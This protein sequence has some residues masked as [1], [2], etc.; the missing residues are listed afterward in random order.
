[1]VNAPLISIIIPTYNVAEYLFQCLNSIA[2]QT[3][4]NFEVIIIIDGATDN[5][6]DIA[7]RF[8]KNDNRFSVYWQENAG[9]GPARNNGLCRATGDFIMF[10]DPDD[11]CK[12]DYIETMLHL[13]QRNDYDLVTVS[14]T[15]VYFNK[16]GT[17]KKTQPP[18][19]HEMQF[20]GAQ[21]VHNNYL[22]LLKEGAIQAPH[23]R[24]YKASIIKKHN[25]R[26]P[27]LRRSQDIVFNYRYY[28]YVQSVLVCN[29]SG[30]MYRVLSK[31]R[32]KR[33]KADYYQTIKIIY[34]DLKTI[35]K[36][37]GSP[38]DKKQA[39]TI[40]YGMIYPL[41]ESNTMRG[42]DIKSIADDKIIYEIIKTAR[43]PKL[44][45]RIVQMAVLH[46]HYYFAT[47]I[48]KMIFRLKMILF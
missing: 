19:F 42:D 35:H 34:N 10:V 33:V 9:S 45:L 23:C 25:I 20:H 11:W 13:Q 26:F 43:P 21:Y 2:E 40:L 30:Y 44:H 29:Y 41:F 16:K 22:T 8:C 4:K 32:A 39:C 5:S 14:E 1:M 46:G 48:L 36:K 37:W 31:E 12:K 28:D 24:I 15:T 18:H 7:K 27:D 17:V 38:F 6:Y 47:I 3:Y